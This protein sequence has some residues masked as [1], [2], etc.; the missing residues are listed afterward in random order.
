MSFGKVLNATSPYSALNGLVYA[1]DGVLHPPQGDL[2][3]FLQADPDT[4]P[5]AQLLIHTGLDKLVL[6]DPTATLTVFVPSR[7]ALDSIPDLDKI[8]ADKGQLTS[9]LSFHIAPGRLFTP[10]LT[11]STLTKVDDG[12]DFYCTGP[13]QPSLLTS[14][15]LAYQVVRPWQTFISPGDQASFSAQLVRPDINLLNGVVH[16][17]DGILTYDGYCRPS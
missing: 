15:H 8:I 7:A 2:M 11:N 4:A 9:V 13:S 6:S 5:F 3:T 17:L 10:V 12:T 16:V 1:L 14:H